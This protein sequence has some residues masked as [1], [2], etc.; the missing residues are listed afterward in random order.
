MKLAIIGSRNLSVNNLEKYIPDL[1]KIEII[2]SGGAKGIDTCAKY[3]AVS[4]GIDIIEILPDYK[5][6]G[7]AAPLVRNKLIVQSVDEAVIFWNG[8]SKGTA[9]VINELKQQNKKFTLYIYKNG[10]YEKSY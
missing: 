2:V 7:R 5:K 6:Y 9:F 1:H 10:K 4:R 8:K 3:F